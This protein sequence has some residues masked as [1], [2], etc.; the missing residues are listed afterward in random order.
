MIIL[1]RCPTFLH[2]LSPF[3]YLNVKRPP[4]TT[5]SLVVTPKQECFPAA[6]SMSAEPRPSGRS[7]H[8][9]SSSAGLPIVSPPA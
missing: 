5:A 7:Q 8:A 2:N 3:L 4:C 1:G 9:L 6:G